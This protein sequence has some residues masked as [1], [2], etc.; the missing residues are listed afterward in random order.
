MEAGEFWGKY[1]GI[2]FRVWGYSSKSAL[3]ANV[4]AGF[5]IFLPK[6]I[7]LL[8]FECGAGLEPPT[9]ASKAAGLTSDDEF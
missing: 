2:S 6:M 5:R 4:H 3:I 8:R 7:S 9:T 1:G